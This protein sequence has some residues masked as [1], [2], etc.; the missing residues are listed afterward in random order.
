MKCSFIQ[1]YLT[2]KVISYLILFYLI[3]YPFSPAVYRGQEHAGNRDLNDSE[4]MLL[5]NILFQKSLN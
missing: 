4:V 3:L 2:N 5:W 1:P